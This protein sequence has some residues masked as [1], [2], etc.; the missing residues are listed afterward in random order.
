[1]KKR[2]KK[3]KVMDFTDKRMPAYDVYVQ[4]LSKDTEFLLFECYRLR[5][6]HVIK[7]ITVQE[8]LQQEFT[9]IFTFEDIKFV[10][11]VC[12]MGNWKCEMDF[13][14]LQL[15]LGRQCAKIL[16]SAILRKNGPPSKM[17][18][19]HIICHPDGGGVDTSSIFEERKCLVI[20]PN[21]LQ[22][23]TREL[24]YIPCSFN[25]S[26]G[27]IIVEKTCLFTN[28][29]SRT[30][31][32]VTE[33]LWHSTSKN[34][35]SFPH[36]AAVCCIYV[37][38]HSTATGFLLFDRYILTNAH[39]INGSI[40]NGVLTRKV[41]V[42]FMKGGTYSLTLN[43][44]RKVVAY[45]CNAENWQWE[46]DF[47]LLELDL[48]DQEAQI[49]P[50]ALLSTYGPPSE[51]GRIAIIGHPGGG[52]KKIAEISIIEANL[53]GTSLRYYTTMTHGSSGS[54][55]IGDNL[56]L[57]GM[58]TGGNELG[59][60]SA[61]G[62]GIFMRFILENLL[63]NLIQQMK[64][65]MQ[66]QILTDDEPLLKF[67][68]EAMKGEHTI[69]LIAEFIWRMLGE[70]DVQCVLSTVITNAKTCSGFQNLLTLLCSMGQIDTN[71][72]TILQDYL[73]EDMEVD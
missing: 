32:S 29:A 34:W 7:D 20:Y 28:R 70:Q 38:D 30:A 42:K 52:G 60:G 63:G 23:M 62:F 1:M 50:P 10:A 31:V 64:K 35:Q 4:D 41:F 24:R 26:L 14:L 72:L 56:H 25:R 43:V 12:Y 55:I 47:A 21:D 73:I 39:V 68:F 3:I 51:M 15:D 71:K 5:N 16:P 9:V 48:R 18:G 13:G 37:K 2:K 19:I 61:I 69:G 11:Y 67:I 44:K 17:G 45:V 8:I 6:V 49:L 27:Y 58:H 36:C 57:L 59:N 22:L 40:N 65:Q 46:R 53:Q 54:P 33:D 66:E